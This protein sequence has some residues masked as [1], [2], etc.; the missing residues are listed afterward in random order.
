MFDACV[1]LGGAERCGWLDVPCMLTSI[2]AG[3][4]CNEDM[5]VRV[6]T[7]TDCTLLN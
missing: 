4:G 7:P 3:E 2:G 5:K 6:T 1:W